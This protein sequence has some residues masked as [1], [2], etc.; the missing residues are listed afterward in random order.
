MAKERQVITDKQ[1]LWTKRIAD[2]QSSGLSQGAFCEQHGLTY[3]TFVYWRGRL[4]KLEV[5][6]DASTVNFFPVRLK[7]DSQHSLTLKING[8]HSIEIDTNFD[9][10]LLT[11]VIQVV[12]QIS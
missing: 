9:S 7:K 5:R 3:T 6:D 11:R 4:K 2:W 12:E 8:R 1:T 10:D